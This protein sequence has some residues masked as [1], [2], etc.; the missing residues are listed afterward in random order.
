MWKDGLF[1]G[2]ICAYVKE[3][4]RFMDSLMSGVIAGFVEFSLFY[5]D[6]KNM[7]GALGEKTLSMV[8]TTICT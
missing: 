4:K 6:L 8:I 5:S 3:G 7:S 1:K 2:W